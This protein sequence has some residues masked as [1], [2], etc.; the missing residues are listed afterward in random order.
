M[1]ES[2]H[3]QGTLEPKTLFKQEMSPLEGQCLPSIRTSRRNG[4]WRIVV[5]NKW[6]MKCFDSGGFIGTRAVNFYFESDCFGFTMC[7]VRA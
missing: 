2:N 3:S 5:E 7:T 6:T 4:R 1:V